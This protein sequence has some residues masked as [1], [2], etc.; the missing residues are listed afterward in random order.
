MDRSLK[1]TLLP[2]NLNIS[3]HLNG[4]VIIILK[5][6]CCKLISGSKKSEFSNFL[7]FNKIKPVYLVYVHWRLS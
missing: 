5:Y 6:N 3:V 2:G 7:H 4:C 1:D